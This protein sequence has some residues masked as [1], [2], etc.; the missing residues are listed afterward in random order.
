MAKPLYNASDMKN[1]NC[2][3]SPIE[4]SNWCL[5]NAERSMSR[6]EMEEAMQWNSL[7]AH[8][9][10]FSCAVLTSPELERQLIKIGKS[11]KVPFNKPE[12]SRDRKKRWLHVVT[13][14]SSFGGHSSMLRNWM[15]L[16]P[17][18]NNHSI[19]LLE[20]KGKV[21]EPIEEA[22]KASGGN[23]IC[24]EAKSSLISRARYLR[25]IVWSLA[26]V[27]VLHIHPWD[28]IATVALSIPGGPPVL[29]VNH[30]AHQFW[31]GASVTDMILNCRCSTQEDEWASKCRGIDE[32]MHLPIPIIEQIVIDRQDSA[33]RAEARKSLHLPKNAIAILTIGM[34]YKYKPI[35]GIDF[36]KA[37]SI[38]LKECKNAYLIAVGPNPDEHWLSL[39][40]EVPGRLL[41]VKKLAQ[42]EMSTY[43]AAADLYLEG[44]PFG[45]T[46]ALLEAC[47]SGIPCVLPPKE[48]PP[49]FIS[50]GIALQCLEQPVTVSDYV[51]LVMRLVQDRQERHR[52]G[53]LLSISVKQHHCGANW[54]DYLA[55]VQNNLPQVHKVKMIDDI[56]KVPENLSTYWA[57]ISSVVNGDP[58][59]FVCKQDLY[60]ELS[61]ELD[62]Y[63]KGK[64]GYEHDELAVILMNIG[65]YYFWKRKFLKAR[66]YY[67]YAISQNKFFL[68]VWIKYLLLTLGFPGIKLRENIVKLKL[69]S[70]EL[71]HSKF[72][73]NF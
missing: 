30:A 5:A 72:S 1:R 11:F 73:F 32:I 20:Q 19:V 55:D 58:L 71:G 70:I 8:V 56:Q 69:K 2:L 49:P 29:L 62:E 27:V 9:L 38:V 36:F 33:Y 44:F 6:Q 57:R 35:E 45:S 43:F 10:S 7:A 39:R 47:L 37:V 22:V 26:D 46:T 54:I 64:T 48:C 16:D 61:I 52:V 15:E 25:E 34:G 59:T 66:K 42:L 4:V 23:V 3:C 17:K 40:R 68:Q 41:L 18:E 63:L 21:P 13:M 65:D 60:P 50:D 24:M 31:V 51:K 14:V 28:V 12:T 53:K 67:I